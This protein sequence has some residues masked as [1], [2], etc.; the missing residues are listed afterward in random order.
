MFLTRIALSQ[1]ALK[2]R[3]GAI[4]KKRIRKAINI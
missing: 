1:Q 2:I 4:K 3:G